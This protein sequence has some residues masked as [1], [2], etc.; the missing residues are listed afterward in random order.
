MNTAGPV[1][2]ASETQKK[3]TKYVFPEVLLSEASFMSKYAIWVDIVR[4]HTG[5]Y[6]VARLLPADS[7]VEDAFRS[8][9]KDSSYAKQN[10]CKEQ[11][12]ITR[13]WELS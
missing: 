5:V 11:G 8:P 2:C 10:T 7:S 1:G 6:W 4:V 9:C 13:A 3:Y 12:W